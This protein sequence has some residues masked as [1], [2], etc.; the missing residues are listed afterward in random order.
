MDVLLVNPRYNGRS[1]I[2]PLGL[3]YI[4]A[5]LLEKGVHVEILDLDTV[6]EKQADRS[7]CERLRRLNPGIVGVTCLSNSF[8]SALRTCKKAKANNAKTLTVMGGMHP[9]VLAHELLLSHAEIDLIVRGEGEHTFG[10]VVQRA[11]QK[12]D[13]TGIDGLSFR[14]AGKVVHEADRNLEKDLDRFPRP[15]HH[16]CENSRYVTRSL[17]SSRGCSR[18]CRFCSIQSQYRRTVRMRGC[19]SLLDEI[20]TLLSLGARKIMFTDDNFTFS[21]Q[22][23]RELCGRMIAEG[24]GKD[25]E[26]YAQGRIDDICRLPVLAGMMSAAGFRG[27]YIG[28]ESG[29]G[30]ILD[31]YRKDVTP[32]DVLSGVACCVEQ[33]LT[34]VVNFILLGPQDDI[35]TIRETIALAKRVF[36][37]GA[38]IAYAE[39]LIPYP[40]TPILESLQRDGKL[41]K[42]QDVYAFESYH[43]I[44]LESFLRQCDLSRE[45]ARRMHGGDKFFP[46]KKAYYELHIL[47]QILAGDMNDT[48][49]I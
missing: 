43:G 12:A 29:S 20:E 10:E 37:C 25:V 19:E 47:D 36:E 39:N 27:L 2:P 15:A 24:F 30:R 3:E 17:S 45:M 48:K 26:F 11:T 13:F 46:M 14:S 21:P 1:E 8:A 9:S 35:G 18:P 32:E 31:Y 16:L 4:A 40:G 28:A 33:N 22:R 42:F 7:L 41:R 6:A 5:P 49:N 38:E 34:P 23:V 44:N